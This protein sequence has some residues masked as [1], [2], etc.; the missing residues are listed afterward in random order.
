MLV[1]FHG[2]FL[3]LEKPYSIGVD[4]ISSITGLSR[5][6]WDP[7]ATFEKGKHLAEI[8][9]VKENFGM[10][11][12]GEE[13]LISSINDPTTHMEATILAH[14]LLRVSIPK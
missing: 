10:V 4:Q 11:I 6:G 3:W 1:V 7:V 12:S 5:A 9:H 14:K 13:L 2:G 8:A